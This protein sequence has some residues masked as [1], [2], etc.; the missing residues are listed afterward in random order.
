LIDSTTN[1][2]VWVRCEGNSASF[3]EIDGLT[4]TNTSHSND[5]R[6]ELF[7][8]MVNAS[9]VRKIYF[10]TG[11]AVDDG[12]PGT[13]EFFQVVYNPLLNSYELKRFGVLDHYYYSVLSEGNSG[14]GAGAGDYNA[15]YSNRILATPSYNANGLRVLCNQM[16]YIDSYF[17]SNDTRTT[18]FKYGTRGTRQAVFTAVITVNGVKYERKFLID[19]TG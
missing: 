15:W 7:S 8:I 18:N 11:K 10:Y 12:S 1:K 3:E 2:F 4:S 13:N 16:A 17:L 19:V 5:D 9:T 14:A 6:V